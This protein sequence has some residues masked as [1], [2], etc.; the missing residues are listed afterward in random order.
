MEVWE[1]KEISGLEDRMGDGAS[2]WEEPGCSSL[3]LQRD[4]GASEKRCSAGRW[5][6][7]LRPSWEVSGSLGVITKA[8]EARRVDE[9]GSG[10][11]H[12]A[13]GTSHRRVGAIVSEAQ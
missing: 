9:E 7:G 5:Y 1:G 11:G 3:E 8:T 12:G 4:F 10:L 2:R 13:S 6:V